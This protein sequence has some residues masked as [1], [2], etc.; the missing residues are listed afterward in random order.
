MKQELRQGQMQH[1][2]HWSGGCPSGSRSFENPK[3]DKK[4][5]NRDHTSSLCS[6]VNQ[7]SLKYQC[8]HLGHVAVSLKDT[9]R[10]VG[11]EHS[12]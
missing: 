3:E 11:E 9:A 12:A 4:Q 8:V 2:Q 6:A 1:K 5:R 7:Q 10:T